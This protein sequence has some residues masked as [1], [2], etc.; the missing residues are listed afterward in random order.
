MR[1]TWCRLF[2][3]VAAAVLM[4]GCGKKEDSGRGASIIEDVIRPHIDNAD[5][6]DSPGY[7]Q[8]VQSFRLEGFSRNGQNQWSV[9][10]KF[11]NIVDPDIFLK[12]LKGASVSET[13]SVRIS[14]D[15]GVYNKDTRSATLNGNVVVT[16]ADGG[17]ALME[18]ANWDATNEIITTDSAIRIEHSGVILE[19]IGAEVKPQDE[20]AIVKTDV[21]MWDEKGRTIT[22]DG[23]LEVVYREKKAILNNN[24][25]IDDPQGKMYADKV[26][27]HFNPETREIERVEWMG[28]VKAVY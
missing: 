11:A 25:E 19:G 27:A 1:K 26:I 16:M 15:G 18:H 17:R 4:P 13:M 24:V 8:E 14:A 5:N 20:W 10:G 7:K 23:P 3:I 6:G 21:R 28:N 22:C 12:S 9:Q 2:I